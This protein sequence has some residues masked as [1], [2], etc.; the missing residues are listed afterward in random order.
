MR[1]ETGGGGMPRV[2]LGPVG[3]QLWQDRKL[4]VII[5]T[6][7]S[8][9]GPPP[10]ITVLHWSLS[11]IEVILRNLVPFIQTLKLSSYSLDGR[12][13]SLCYWRGAISRI[14]NIGQY[15]G[16]FSAKLKGKV[17]SP[18]TSPSVV[19]WEGIKIFCKDLWVILLPLL[20]A[21]IYFPR[22]LYTGILENIV[23]NSNQT[24]RGERRENPN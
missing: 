3:S 1:W 10:V 4:I 16:N 21:A 15:L 12:K 8:P 24:E 5:K 22:N 7:S 23:S 17:E 6:D 2:R 19:R 13:L 14:C 9:Q 11:E 18:G 20:M